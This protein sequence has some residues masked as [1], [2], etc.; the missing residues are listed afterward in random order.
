VEE[1][2]DVIKCEILGKEEYNMENI[3]EVSVA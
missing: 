1:S 3:K 2:D